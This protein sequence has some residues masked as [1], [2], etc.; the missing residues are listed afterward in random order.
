MPLLKHRKRKQD[1]NQLILIST[2]ASRQTAKKNILQCVE[3]LVVMVTVVT[4][5]EFNDR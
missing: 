3:W 4:D 5:E 1:C 2:N